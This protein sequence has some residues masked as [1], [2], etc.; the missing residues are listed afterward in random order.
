MQYAGARN[1]RKADSARER[2]NARIYGDIVS[3]IVTAELGAGQRLKEQDLARTYKVSRTPIREILIALEKDGLVKR[4]RNRG[5]EVISMTADD[6]EHIFDIR[7]S[8]ECLAVRRATTHMPLNEL[9]SLEQRFEALE[10]RKGPQ[11]YPN[12]A[13]LDSEL[14]RF[15]VSE[16]RNPLLQTYLRNISHLIH[17]LRLSGNHK[18]AYDRRGLQEHLAIVRAL[19]RRDRQSAE[20]LLADHI[21][22]SKNDVLR[23]FFRKRE[24]AKRQALTVNSGSP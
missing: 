2:T 22:N 4:I 1:Q 6:L 14:H 11:W 9:L 17:S 7:S 23:F 15:I 24:T 12:L 5:A 16:S 18:E 20:R 10:R 8:L 19:I 3:K 13:E 21:E